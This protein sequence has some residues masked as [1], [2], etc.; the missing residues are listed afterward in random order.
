MT[1][2]SLSLIDAAPALR[3]AA[4]QL[5]FWAAVRRPSGWQCRVC[6]AVGQW[7]EIVHGTADGLVCPVGLAQEALRRIE[8]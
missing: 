3:R 7:E 6:G 5:I 8:E 2:I 4:S 1:D